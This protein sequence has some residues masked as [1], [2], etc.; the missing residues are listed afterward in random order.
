MQDSRLAKNESYGGMNVPLDKSQL[1]KIWGMTNRDPEKT[2]KPGLYSTFMHSEINAALFGYK[3]TND[4]NITKR[5]KEDIRVHFG[6]KPRPPGIL[7][8]DESR[9]RFWL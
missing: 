7:G 9:F 2:R 4:L 1:E 3:M 8:I 6:L 5:K